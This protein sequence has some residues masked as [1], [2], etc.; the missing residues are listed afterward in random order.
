MGSSK[1][2]GS[3]LKGLRNLNS[4]K[5]VGSLLRQL[6]I[7]AVK[8]FGQNFLR[9]DGES[10]SIVESLNC[11]GDDI[12]IEIG[13]GLGAL[14]QYLFGK[15]KKLILIEFDKN[16]AELLTEIFYGY[17]DVE[18]INE[19]A[20]K[21]DLTPFF[22]FGGVKVIGNLPYSSGSEILRNF[23]TFPTPVT[24]AVFMLQK[25]VAERYSAIPRTKSYGINSVLIG[26]R[27][28]VEK[29]NEVS[30]EPFFPPPK[31]K[32]LVIRLELKKD[33][34]YKPFNERV[35][36]RVLTCGFKERRK[37]MKKRMP[38]RGLKWEELCSKVDIS[39]QSR[40]EELSIQ[41]WI[42]VARLLDENPL[43]NIPQRDTEIFDVVDNN[44]NIINQA[45][46][47]TIHKEDLLHRAVHV[48]V[49]NRFG[50]LFLQKRSLYKDSS[51]GLWDSS[52]SGHLDSGENYESA[53]ER[54]LKEELGVKSR[55]EFITKLMP[56]VNTGW[57]FIGLYSCSHNGPFNFP[58]SEIETGG[59]FDLETISNWIKC[60]PEDFAPGFIECF[61]VYKEIK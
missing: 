57:E 33:G 19:D 6:N 12:V 5:D 2:K 38:L 50:K 29:L 13:P 48:F 39:I 27:W 17:D 52:C 54:E 55:I 20:V 21:F 49:F 45:D 56:S 18:V 4:V 41:Q 24:N 34:Y 60:R 22:Q 40:A 26:S 43:R 16:I 32:S 36:K 9:D 42:E 47:G 35:L 53:S 7:S 46:R 14:T 10:Q 58:Y 37:Q 15:V 11:N 31:I 44:D 1:Y 3:G 59:F 30:S 51:P 23:L 8:A 61:K 25:E 28:D